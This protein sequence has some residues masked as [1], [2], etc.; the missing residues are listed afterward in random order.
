MKVCCSYRCAVTQ[1]QCTAALALAKCIHH[2]P[3]LLCKTGSQHAC[4][5]A[6]TPMKVCCSCNCTVTQHQCTAALA[7]AECID[8]CPVLLCTTGSQHACVT[9]ITPIKVCC[10]YRCAV[11]Q[12]PRTAALALAKCIH[13]F[14][15]LLCK[16]GSQ[17]PC[18]AAMTP[19]LYKGTMEGCG[20]ITTHSTLQADHEQ[21][22]PRLA[23]HDFD[24]NPHLGPNPTGM[25]E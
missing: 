4:V 18:V 23:K 20:F 25:D 21:L 19:L 12:H 7:W 11:T 17:H 10:S 2:C 3:V 1:H 15:V 16:T 13:H 8:Y 9:A 24:L 22:L 6:M 14:P 5:T